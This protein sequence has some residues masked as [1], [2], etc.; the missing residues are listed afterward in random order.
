MGALTIFVGLFAVASLGV[1]A[2]AVWRVLKTPGMRHKAAWVVGCLCGFIGFSVGY[3]PG[4][5]LLLEIGVQIPV[6]MLRWS[7]SDATLSIKVLFPLVAVAALAVSR[8][9][10]GP[11]LSD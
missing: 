6:V 9:Q 11:V 7:V 2:G 3:G 5:D 8:R 10:H 1:S 4:G